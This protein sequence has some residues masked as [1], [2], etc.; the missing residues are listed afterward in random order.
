MIR[1]RVWESLTTRVKDVNGRE[2][3]M[4]SLYYYDR[5]II[6]NKIR[7]LF[8]IMFLIAKLCM[9]ICHE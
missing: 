1:V 2:E 5:S 6:E 8:L 3:T 7:R 4:K 9:H